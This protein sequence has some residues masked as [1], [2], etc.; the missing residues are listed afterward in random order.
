MS[1]IAECEPRHWGF[2]VYDRDGGEIA[3]SEDIYESEA[4]A[5]QAASFYEDDPR[6]GSHEVY[7]A[8]V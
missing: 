6:Y 5:D 3:E 2:T 1:V 7:V 4:E 8:D